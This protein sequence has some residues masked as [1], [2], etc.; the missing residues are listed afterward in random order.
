MY[1]TA[2]KQTFL[3]L[4]AVFVLLSL[5]EW[6]DDFMSPGLSPEDLQAKLDT[7]QAPLVVDLRKRS[8]SLSVISTVQSTYRWTNSHRVSTPCDM[9]TG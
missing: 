6:A 1:R 2:I 9:I 3:V 8:S 7:P 4:V 5:P